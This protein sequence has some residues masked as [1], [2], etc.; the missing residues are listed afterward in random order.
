MFMHKITWKGMTA[1]ISK[2]QTIP[3]ARTYSAPH[4]MSNRNLAVQP[5]P[6]EKLQA[7]EA[8]R[9]QFVYQHSGS[10]FTCNGVKRTPDSRCGI[11]WNEIRAKDGVV[12]QEG[13]VD[14]PDCDYLIPSL[15]VDANG[16]IGLG[17]TRTSAKEYPSVYVMIHAANDPPNTMRP[18]VLAAKGTAAFT[19]NRSKQYGIG[20]GSYSS[21]CLDPSDPTIFWTYQQYAMS[22]APGQWTTCWVAFKRK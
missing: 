15:A 7:G 4:P 13:I 21:T 16:N 8:R 10:L 17:C 6:G 2:M 9:T 12:L 3:L 5:A 14:D 1:S 18:A 11:Y 19:S 20:W 22:S